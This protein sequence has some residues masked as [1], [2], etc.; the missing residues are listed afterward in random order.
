MTDSSGNVVSRYD[1]DPWGRQTV[2]TGTTV[3][4]IGYA[5]YW[6]LHSAGSILNLKLNLT[7]YRAYSPELGR[8]LSRDPIAESGGWNLYAYVRNAPVKLN[9]L[10]GLRQGYMY[11]TPANCG[12]GPKPMNFLLGYQISNA[13]LRLLLLLEPLLLQKRLVVQVVG[14]LRAHSRYSSYMIPL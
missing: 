1:Y 9:D 11:E 6:N 8:W 2:V 13:G 7:W 3:F 4:D 5:G 12:D 14:G 10:L